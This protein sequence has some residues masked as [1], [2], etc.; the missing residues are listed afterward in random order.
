MDAEFLP[1]LIFA[2]FVVFFA[3]LIRWS[4]RR[5]RAIYRQI[6][7]LGQTPDKLALLSSRVNRWRGESLYR[8]P[9]QWRRG[10]ILITSQQIAI[11]ER[12]L[13]MPLRFACAPDQAQWFGRPNKYQPGMNEIWL[14]IEADATWQL[15]KIRLF[16]ADM[17]DLVRAL[18]VI[19]TPELVTAYRRQ[20]PYLHRGPV[21]AQP[22]VQDIHGAWTLS[23]PVDIYLMPRFLLIL[24][25]RRVERKIGL[26]T[27]QQIGALRRLDAPGARGLVRFQ[28]RDETLA[29]ALAD[30]AAFAEALA[31]AAKRTLE[32][33]LEQ[34]QKKKDDDWDEDE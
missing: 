11:Y 17:R 24:H 15:V 7:R 28:V 31:A 8:A 25:E 18:K 4:V 12:T 29:F 21:S 22:A 23:K 32:A 10:V 2:G 1:C 9:R 14:H 33:P 13:E 16:H 27:I 26:E 5:E 6:E 34:K 3:V 30:H 19:C 20:R